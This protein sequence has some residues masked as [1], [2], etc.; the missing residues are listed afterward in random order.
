MHKF[1]RTITS[2]ESVVLLFAPAIATLIVLALTGSAVGASKAQAVKLQGKVES[3]GT[4][5]A[6]YTVSLYASFVDH[7]PSW[8][9]LSSDTSDNG[10]NFQIT[11]SLPPGLSDD[12]QPLLFVEAEHGPVMLASAIGMG[13]SALSDVV[14]NER[15]T[16]ATGNAFAQFVDAGKIGGNTYGMI[17][18]VQMAANL[19][20]PQTGAVSIVLAST[21]NGTETSTFSTFKSLSNVVAGCVADTHNCTRLFEAATPPGG[22]APTNVLQA[23]ANIAKNPS[24]PG[25][26]SDTND[27]VFLLSEVNPIY[28]PA[29][30][31]RPTNWLLFLKITGGFYKV[32]DS[33]NL[34]DGPG[35]FAI[36]EL[37][38]V[39]INDNYDPRPS[40]EFACAGRRLIKL[41]PWG[42]NFP[43]S[44]YF[45]GGLEGAGYGITLDPTGNVW[46]A[47]FGFQDAPCDDLPIA[48]KHNSVSVFRPD[49]IAITKGDG[50][51]QG[52]MSWPM[53]VVPDRQGNIWV[54]NCGNDSVT[55]FPGGDP[56]RAINIPLGPTP[57]ANDPQI[58]P[59]GAVVDAKGNLWV[60]GNRDHTVYVISPD[61]TLIDTLPGTYQRKTILSHPIGNAADSK[62]NVWV[63]NSDWLDT[64]CPTHTMLGTAT[65]PS[66]TMFQAK[67]RTP[68][69]G[70]PFTGGGITLPWGIAVDGNDTVWVF[71]FGAVKVGT[72][73]TTPTGISRFCGVD[74]KK[75]PPGM[76][77]GDPISPDTGYRSDSLQRITGGQIDP[78]GNVWLTNNWKID[79]DGFVNPGGNAVVIAIGAAA[80]VKTPLIGPP[81]SFK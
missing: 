44:P 81:V 6:G 61:G 13:S 73:T 72:S 43:G 68:Y 4:G 48:A 5:L 49:G 79:S 37:G 28:Q 38:F 57:P 24:Y 70:S 15:T 64:P 53:T 19:A 16:V 9:L 20:D 46:V 56:N 1:M 42:E 55:K 17:N 12:Q 25:Y 11:Y 77:V 75:C 36:D 58:K 52:N 69:P 23:V 32:Q 59:F 47:N 10:G 66:V 33:S 18:A 60:N 41:Y 62:G 54:T 27:P 29:L 74:T 76:R 2:A 3:G 45:G 22:E 7:G 65:N 14:V 31:Q 8:K 39:W 34:M 78:S 63:S 26:P 30:T 21:P 35:N 80:P 67:D 71:N 51:T 40:G 50:Y